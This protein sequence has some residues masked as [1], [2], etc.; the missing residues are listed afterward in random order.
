[1]DVQ[2]KLKK[3][4]QNKSLEELASLRGLVASIMND[5]DRSLVSYAEIHED[6]FFKNMPEDIK[7]LHE[8]RSKVFTL[9]MCI[10]DVIEDKLFKI[11][12]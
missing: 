1:M 4:F 10:N 8:K 12:E 6:K 5:Y 2:E 9:L 11:Y 7:V 3:Y